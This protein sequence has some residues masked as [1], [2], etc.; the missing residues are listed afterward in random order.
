[1]KTDNV[2]FGANPLNRVKIKK[3]N[4]IMKRFENFPARFVRLEDDYNDISVLDR[5]AKEWKNAK[6]IKRIASS[7]HWMSIRD[8]IEIDVYALTTQQNNFKELIYDKIL[9]FAE[10]RND[11]KNRKKRILNRLQVRPDAINLGN[12]NNKNF[13]RIGH[14]I[15]ESLKKIYN[16]LHLDS[17]NLLTDKFYIANGFIQDKLRDGSF[18]WQSNIFKRLYLR[19]K[20]LRGM[21]GY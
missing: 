6:Y 10:I 20:N 4:N 18:V 14:S 3:Y 19:Y 12:P 8:D 17:E 15:L 2:V 7:S 21:F 16:N 1:M 5:A 13:K 9:G 11:S